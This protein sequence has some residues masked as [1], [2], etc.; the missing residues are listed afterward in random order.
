[1][2]IRSKSKYVKWGAT[3]TI[4]FIICALFIYVLFFGSDL[5]DKFKHILSKLSPIITGLCTAFI[6]TPLLNR[7]EY[8]IVRR[9]FKAFNV[10][11]SPKSRK[12]SRFISVFFTSVFF[13]GALYLIIHLFLS[14]VIPSVI[15]FSN[16]FNTYVNN[17][18]NWINKLYA[19]NT[20]TGNEVL[21]Y[22]SKYSKELQSWL[23]N[24]L[25]PQ[26][27]VLLKTV[28]KSLLGILKGLS[29]FIVGFI[30]SIYVMASKET[31]AGQAKKITYALFKRQ[32][33]NIII[34]N[35]RF[36]NKTF[37]G[38]I[39]GKLIDSFIIALLCFIGTSL[40]QTPYGALISLIVGIT[41]IIPFFGPY[42]GAI[43][44]LLLVFFVNPA[45]PSNY[46]SLLI[47]IILLQQFDGNILGPKILE[48]KTGLDGF[49]VIFSITIFGGLFGIYGMLIGVPVFAVI[50]AAFKSYVSVKLREKKLPVTTAEYIDL[51]ALDE[52]RKKR[53]F[54]PEYKM[55]KADHGKSIYGAF[56]MNKYDEHLLNDSSVDD[57]YLNKYY[58]KTGDYNNDE[59]EGS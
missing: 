3:V 45:R 42:I 31:F 58:E 19:N 1:M 48:N 28:T 36:V 46:I 50:Y 14:Q 38:F 53:I 29:H 25:L 27:S 49:W 52:N 34:N 57:E 56:F 11:I 30:I 33:A 41:N 9:I 2:K 54:I 7:I 55:K 32:T 37:A 17:I 12:V 15:S 13:L 44:S 35:F 51:A 20:E 6:L 39:S 26:T 16:N 24:K 43:P 8:N 22:V 18:N 21:Q 10:K 4:C 59:P 5:S 47:F 23:S 40:M